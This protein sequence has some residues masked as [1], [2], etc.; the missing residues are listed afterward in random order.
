MV[1]LLYF[2]GSVKVR[3]HRVVTDRSSR[4]VVARKDGKCGPQSMGTNYLYRSQYS[5]SLDDA[6]HFYKEIVLYIYIYIYIS[7][8]IYIDMNTRC[9]ICARLS[10]RSVQTQL[11][12]FVHPFPQMI[13][14]AR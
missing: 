13:N 6:V 7:I 3:H 10:Q 8:Y 9:T 5:I 12:V 11:F 2:V 14:T 4:I 1:F